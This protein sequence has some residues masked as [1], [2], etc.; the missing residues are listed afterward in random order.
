LLWARD[1]PSTPSLQPKDTLSGNDGYDTAQIDDGNEG[2]IA[3]IEQ[4][5]V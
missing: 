2:P 5:L 3:G 1:I 4:I